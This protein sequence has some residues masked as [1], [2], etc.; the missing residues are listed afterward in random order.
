MYTHLTIF[1]TIR[2]E[3]LRA[4]GI[5]IEIVELIEKLYS[6]TKAQVLLQRDLLIVECLP[7]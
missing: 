4:N 7:L 5:Q 1:S 3:I 6:D 2:M